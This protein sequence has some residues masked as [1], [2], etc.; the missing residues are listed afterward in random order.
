[1][2]KASILI[3]CYN[4]ERWV[5]EAIQSALDQTHPDIEVIV[6]DDGSTDGSLEIIQSFGDKI[7]WETGPNR[8]GNVTRNRLLEL[9]TGEWLQYLD[10]DD[11]LNITKIDVQLQ[12]MGDANADLLWSPSIF[13]YWKDEHVDSQVVQQLVDEDPWVALIRW[14]LPQTGAS[15]WWKQ[16]VIDAG[17]WKAEQPCCQEHELYLRLLKHNAVFKYCPTALS[18]YRQ[19]SESTVCRRDPLKTYRHRAEIITDA[20]ESLS[21]RGEFD[22][23]RRQAAAAALLQCA[24]A[25]FRDH[26]EFSFELDTMATR[27]CRPFQLPHE[28]WF[29]MI[30]RLLYSLFGLRVAEFAAVMLRSIRRKPSPENVP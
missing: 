4:A 9:S 3:P 22:E 8:G 30:W 28:P 1:M 27:L 24:R 17:G 26:R 18:V 15:L 5:A 10:A 14:H 12:E 6:V 11:Y 20:I 21:S 23:K 29:P 2:P 16:A 13:E 7:R 19:W 25:T